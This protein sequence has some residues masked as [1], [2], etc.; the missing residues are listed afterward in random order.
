MGGTT[1]KCRSKT[2][3]VPKPEWMDNGV[4]EYF[5][6]TA[7][8]CSIYGD[9]CI[10]LC[11][12]YG[13]RPCHIASPPGG[14]WTYHRKGGQVI[15]PRRN[16]RFACEVTY[17]QR[18]VH[19]SCVMWWI[20]L[21]V[22]CLAEC[23]QPVCYGRGTCV[24]SS[25]CICDSPESLT[26]DCSITKNGCSLQYCS[27]AGQCTS[28]PTSGHV[29]ECRCDAGY[30]G[31]SCQ[32]REA[33]CA[34]L[35]CS[36]L[37]NCTATG[38]LCPRGLHQDCSQCDGTQERIFRCKTC[39]DGVF[40]PFCNITQSDCSRDRCNSNGRCAGKGCICQGAWTESSNC[41]Q[42]E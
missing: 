42:H 6:F 38:C 22:S 7:F 2:R 36:G 3:R 14:I 15:S 1:G 20:T 17:K 32:V 5:P 29:P 40:G 4:C 26:P 25:S 21:A 13:D 37:S 30:Y 35:L 27:L 8:P 41:S 28:P 33:H 12:N 11:I 34:T 18:Y 31:E 9:S 10:H 16:C 24:N 23:G 19:L 39:V